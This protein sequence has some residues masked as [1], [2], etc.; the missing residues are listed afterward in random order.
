M[1]TSRPLRELGGELRTIDYGHGVVLPCVT[2]ACPTCPDGH[3]HMMPYGPQSETIQAGD[4]RVLVWKHESGATI[5]DLTLSPSYLVRGAC[6]T[7]GF[8]RNGQWEP[9]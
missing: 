9:C 7:H 8:V 1:G 4:R 2:W 3:S 5:D 6:E